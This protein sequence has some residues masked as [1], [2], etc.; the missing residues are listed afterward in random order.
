M[1]DS[2]TK[3]S[4]LFV[5]YF[6]GSGTCFVS[7]PS[8]LPETQERAREI[9]SR[10]EGS[11]RGEAHVCV[12]QSLS[13]LA[14]WRALLGQGCC[15]YS[16]YL[17]IAAPLHPQLF[18]NP[19]P[20]PGHVADWAA[21][22]VYC[23][24]SPNALATNNAQQQQQQQQEGQQQDKCHPLPPSIPSPVH[25]FHS[26]ILYD[27]AGCNF[28]VMFNLQAGVVVIVIGLAIANAIGI[29]IVVV[30]ASVQN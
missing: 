5:A 18:C 26:H 10:G 28:V 13:E 1:L 22:F 12:E 7:L 25:S 23:E 3:Q 20:S 16:I 2:L 30:I 21:S 4:A 6:L 15:L 29:G 17:F 24:S 19:P 14:H 8:K 9:A 27:A 11:E